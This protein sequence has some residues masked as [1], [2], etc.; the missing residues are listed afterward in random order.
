MRSNVSYDPVRDFMPITL[1][2][3]SPNI[4]VVHPSL[5][6]KSVAEL[7]SLVKRKPG[8][9][10]YAT[11][12]AGNSNHLAAELFKSMT[13]TNI[14]RINYKGAA[15]A[16]ND[17]IGGQVQIMFATAGSVMQH[18]KS[19]RLRALAVT[20]AEPSALVS[21]RSEA[22]RLPCSLASLRHSLS[23]L[24]LSFDNDRFAFDSKLGIEP[25]FAS[26]VLHVLN[27]LLAACAR[28]RD[29]IGLWHIVF[30]FNHHGPV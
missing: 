17:L 24:H 8:E 6:V 23:S 4:L 22:S 29:D 12:G 10:Y 5:P 13:A 14:V 18:I 30:A 15:P 26:D 25:R 7:I 19:G 16:L 20:S 3:K 28:D 2:V 21:S 9:I 11:G 1:A 27:D